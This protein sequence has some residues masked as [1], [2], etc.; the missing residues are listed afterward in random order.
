MLL[1]ARAPAAVAARARR[2]RGAAVT[3]AAAARPSAPASARASPGLDRRSLDGGDAAPAVAK[4]AAAAGGAAP[5]P[6]PPAAAGPDGGR[7]LRG[8]A[9][10]NLMTLGM[11]TNWT[12]LRA[13]ATTATMSDATIFMV[14]GAWQQAG[15]GAGGGEGCCTASCRVPSS[16]PTRSTS[17]RP[18]SKAMR[19][20]LAAAVFLPFLRP[21]PQIIKAGLEIGVWYAA[22]YITQASSSGGLGEEG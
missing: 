5:A 14:R 17:P 3:V 16:R 22:G 10:L 6:P 11:A 9:I 19:F 18:P 15:G 1:R 21:R 2:R 7:R 12:V 13:S 20:A 4:A 8:L